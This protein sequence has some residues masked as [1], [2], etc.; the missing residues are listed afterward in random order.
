MQSQRRRGCRSRIRP[1][2]HHLEVRLPLPMHQHCAPRRPAERNHRRRHLLRDQSVHRPTARSGDHLLR[3]PPLP[4]GLGQFALCEARPRRPR[5]TEIRNGLAVAQG[6]ATS[7]AKPH[8]S[9]VLRAI[10][11][12]LLTPAPLKS[13]ANLPHRLLSGALGGRYAS[14]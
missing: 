8:R 9:P 11:K 7:L 1:A 13:L 2:L 6:R 5:F 10:L 12:T 3:L 14:A 4:R